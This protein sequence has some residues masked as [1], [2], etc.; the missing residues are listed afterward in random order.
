MAAV[1]EKLGVA[2]A[3]L[4][5]YVAS[6]DEL[7]ELAAAHALTQH[8]FPSDRGQTWSVWIL[9]YA[10]SLFEIMTTDG[11]LFESWLS[12]A[13]SPMVEVDAAELWLTALTRR[14]FSGGE[15][16]QLR[17]AVSQLVIGASASLKHS[18]AWRSRGQA[19]P[20]S[21]KKVVRGRPRGELPLLHEF[22]DVF[23]REPDADNWEFG[24]FLLLQ[25]VT[26]ARASLQPDARDHPFAK[27]RLRAVKTGD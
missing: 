18:R 10:R 26:I 22:I 23:A 19:R 9:E 11:Q 25:G 21:M 13:Q 16:L 4:Y 17:H 27:Q 14:G 15:A 1:A 12:G 3:V 8:D 24:L 7:V 6:R 2:K 20:L 5:G